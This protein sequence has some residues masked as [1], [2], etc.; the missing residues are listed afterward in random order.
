MRFDITRSSL[1][2]TM[3]YSALLVA[4]FWWGGS[5]SD[6]VADGNTAMWATSW[7]P[8][9]WFHTN[10]PTANRLFSAFMVFVCSILVSKMAI[11]NVIFLERTYMPAVIFVII[12]STFYNTAN[13][14]ATILSTWFIILSTRYVLRSYVIKRLS[15]GIFLIAGFYLGCAVLMFPPA[16]YLCPMLFLGLTIFRLGN[17]KEWI[18]T[19][20]G[21]SFPVAIFFYA[22][23]LL[24]GDMYG[25]WYAFCDAISLSDGT[26][27][28]ILH[29]NLV[30]YA[31]GITTLTLVILSIIKFI[32]YRSQYKLRSALC[33]LFFALMLFWS[34]GVM[35]V[36]PVRTLYFLPIV[37]FPLAVLI[38]NYFAASKPT[39]WS[40]FLY[41]MLLLTSI[42]IHLLR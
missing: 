11:R 25:S 23:W 12:S 32:R 35:T 30:E 36:S 3:L 4:L 22:T 33:Y 18:A 6:A 26:A 37:A 39:F 9:D 20:A 7:A 15:A 19:V 31:F 16:L 17:I 38:P 34:V 42:A 28:R 24:G 8:F 40:N 10:Y 13:S 29:L 5:L 2:S 21:L 1:F 41:A 14:L 27:A